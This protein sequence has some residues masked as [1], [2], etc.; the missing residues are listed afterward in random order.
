MYVEWRDAVVIVRDQGSKTTRRSGGV[1]KGVWS[2]EMQYLTTIHI[3]EVSVI[4]ES[5]ELVLPWINGGKSALEDERKCLS[6]KDQANFIN[7]SMF[8]LGKTSLMASITNMFVISSYTCQDWVLSREKRIRNGREEAC[9]DLGILLP[10]SLHQNLICIFEVRNY[11]CSGG[12]SVLGLVKRLP[13]PLLLDQEALDFIT[14]E[15]RKGKGPVMRLGTLGTMLIMKI[16][17][18]RLSSGSGSESAT[19]TRK[20]AKSRS[21]DAS[22]NNSDS[23]DE[24]DYGSKGL[25]IRDGSDNGS[26]TQMEIGEVLCSRCAFQELYTKDSRSP[27]V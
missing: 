14:V 17:Y 1:L 3:T 26:G 21:N 4:M 25:S 8:L 7:V 19:H 22:E 24:N 27:L 6:Y 11:D 16:V 20:S 2:G 9:T 15:Q 10:D 13:V 5:E 23:S 12:S 18:M